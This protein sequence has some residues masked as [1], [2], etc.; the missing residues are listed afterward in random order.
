M[1]PRLY[2]IER[3]IYHQRADALAQTLRLF[4]LHKISGKK[5]LTKNKN[6]NTILQN[7]LKFQFKNNKNKKLNGSFKWGKTSFG[8]LKTH[9]NSWVTF[10]SIQTLYLIKE[11]L[12]KK[13]SHLEPFD[14]I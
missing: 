4:F 12:E 7:L 13:K 6:I 10:F 3:I 1:P 9:A 14:L 11:T 5:I 2:L 8:K